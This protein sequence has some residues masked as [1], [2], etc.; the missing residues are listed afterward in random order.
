MASRR[1]MFVGAALLLGEQVLAQSKP[2]D[3]GDVLAV[4]TGS[5]LLLLGIF[6]AL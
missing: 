5:V 2:P 3:G 6:A 4:A 1:A